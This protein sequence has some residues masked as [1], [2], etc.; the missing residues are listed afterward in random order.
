MSHKIVIKY[1]YLQSWETSSN[2]GLLVFGLAKS[3]LQLSSWAK[4]KFKKIS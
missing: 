3:D 1:N 2:M 4:V